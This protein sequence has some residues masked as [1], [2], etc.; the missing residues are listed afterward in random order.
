MNDARATSAAWAAGGLA[1][2][3]L[4]LSA[5]TFA[6][7]PAA[8]PAAPADH[9]APST[10]RVVAGPLDVEAESGAPW[11]WTNLQNVGAAPVT[12]AVL[13]AAWQDGGS[14]KA[15]VL[16][17]DEGPVSLFEG[18]AASPS[19][20]PLRAVDTGNPVVLP[21]GASARLGLRFEAGV[22][23]PT[24]GP[25]VLHMREGCAVALHRAVTDTCGLEAT[26]VRP[27]GNNPNRIV[28]SVRN[29]GPLA[30]DLRALDVY[31]PHET[32]GRLTALVLGGNDR[33]EIAEGAET[34]PAL[35]RLDRLA[36]E[37][38]RLE[39]GTNVAVWLEFER[40]VAE[41]PYVV[42]LVTADGCRVSATT[43]LDTPGC[44]IRVS[45]FETLGLR[46]RV[47][48]S[49]ALP[50]PQT[51]SSLD[52]YWPSGV[53][54]ALVAVQINGQPI[55]TGR[56]SSS[57]ATVT[58]PDAPSIDA[59]DGA[60]LDVVFAP[61]DG[62][63]GDPSGGGTIS[64]HDFTFVLGWRGGCRVV[65][66][67]LRAP[68]AGC[69]V[70]AGT[71]APREGVP[72]VEV[73]LTNTGGDARMRRL[74]VSWPARNGALTGVTFGTETL[75]EGEQPPAAEPF[76]ILPPPDAAWLS[77]G[78]TAPLRLTFETR[79]SDTGYA[80]S[81]SFVDA[82][83]YACA[84][85]LVTPP[86]GQK[87][88]DL[89]IIDVDQEAER[90]VDVFV[91]HDGADEVELSFVNV[92]WPT[93]DGRNRLQRVLLQ[94]GDVEYPLWTGEAW[95]SPARVPLDGERAAVIDPGETVRLRLQYNQLAN[96]PD[97]AAVF[98][99]AV[100]TL[101]GCQAFYPGDDRET[102]PERSSFNG[103]IVGLPEDG[104]WGW[105]TIEAQLGAQREQRLVLVKSTTRLEPSIVRPYVGA[106]VRVE[107]LAYDDGWHAEKVS[108][109]SFD[110]RVQLLGRVTDLERDGPDPSRP[111]WLQ[112]HNHA[113][114]IWIV[115]DTYVEGRLAVGAQ[116]AVVG[117]VDPT[118]S[119][120][121]IEIKLQQL[122]QGR[123]VTVRGV[124][125]AARRAPEIGESIQ[126][127][128]VDKYAVRVDS[129]NPATRL[130]NPLGR[131]ARPG[132]RLE[133]KGLLSGVV[134]EASQV[135]SVPEAVRA[136]ISGLLVEA[137]PGSLVG[138]WVV[139][140]TGG[141]EIRFTVE[142]TAVVDVRSAPAVPGIQ[143]R[144]ELED[145]GGGRWTA[146]AV[147]TDWPD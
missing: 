66:S 8:V 75:F 73:S 119:V 132:E 36:A 72:E 57:P 127:W 81:L 65:F 63:E 11:A 61:N 102:R 31:W 46:A 38:Y 83:G 104:L 33:F 6:G 39:P 70:S 16:E 107:A 78:S 129:R 116:V 74:L 141:E 67:T 130:E 86:G 128:T 54:G 20:F 92:D 105:W 77:S 98:K 37:P 4:L 124:V 9:E 118:G 32:N 84:D 15:V 34:S 123:A 43:W 56:V 142:S 109:R 42:S 45:D 51:L 87:G 133:I 13:Q 111:A 96:V 35:V 25:T 2:G 12:L 94:D 26:D 40:P 145:A 17:T 24:V 114:R 131:L 22:A 60:R 139:R 62:A 112:L 82:D 117:T 110:Q 90:M 47:R 144:A 80:L 50:A 108:F 69:Q 135:A 79:A 1:L 88:C 48:L 85:L 147:Q 3:V 140:R 134:I 106:I 97:P 93:E 55:W 44:G 19:A 14:L 113:Q 120:T 136:S 138:P 27:S 146:L 71:L 29:T 101:E 64:G 53:N 7:R 21:E 59:H 103:L 137:P 18:A 68:D 52:L 28:L 91:R 125:Q 122:P 76:A 89:A 10:C 23:A 41:G 143:V 115:A 121:A 95:V 49:N 58:F 5:W 99:M 100:G 126:L 30:R